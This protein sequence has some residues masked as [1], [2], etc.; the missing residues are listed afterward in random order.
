M[1]TVIGTVFVV[2]WCGLGLAGASLRADKGYTSDSCGAAL[3]G[4][5][6]YLLSAILSPRRGP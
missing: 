2:A 6:L 4:G 5:P 3:W 1:E